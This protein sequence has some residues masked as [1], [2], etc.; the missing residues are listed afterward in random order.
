MAVQTS[1]FGGVRLTGDD[2]KALRHQVDNP[3]PN[4]AAA[5]SLKEGRKLLAEYNENGFVRIQ[6]KAQ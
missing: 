5:N 3:Q 4:R 2:A 6:I 1:T